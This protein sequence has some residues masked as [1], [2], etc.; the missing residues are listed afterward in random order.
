MSVQRPNVE[1]PQWSSD[2][3]QPRPRPT[4][5]EPR[6]S[7]VLRIVLIGAVG[8]A[9]LVPLF[10]IGTFVRPKLPPEGTRIL[11][12]DGFQFQHPEEWRVLEGI[13]FGPATAPGL[14]LQA[15]GIDDIN[16]VVVSRYA[17]N[18]AVTDDNV[19]EVDGLIRSRVSEVLA[20]SGSWN[21]QSEQTGTTMA[22]HPAY[23]WMV[24]SSGPGG[25]QVASR[26]TVVVDGS[27]MFVVSCQ[28][29]LERALEVETGCDQVVDT[30]E[31][32]P[33]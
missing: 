3:L 22:G 8:V 23:R 11:F 15:V 21:I 5:P 2:W 30:F 7:S 27:T 13:R 25:V 20:G 31:I 33:A 6:R 16:A 26:V 10:F 1:E 17:V 32:A 29:S 12:G 9:V 28:H 19:D 14:S 4:R 24:T 18:F